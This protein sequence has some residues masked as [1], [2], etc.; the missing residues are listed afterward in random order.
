MKKKKT[1]MFNPETYDK[2]NDMD[3]LL[4]RSETKVDPK[5]T[6][7]G[8]DAMMLERTATLHRNKE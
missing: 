7:G 8:T 1:V 2:N 6:Y 3:Y 5:M 4:A